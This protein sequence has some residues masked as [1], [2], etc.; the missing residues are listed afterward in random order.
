MKIIQ[1]DNHFTLVGDVVAMHCF[2]RLPSQLNSPTYGATTKAL[3]IRERGI[4]EGEAGG[5]KDK[6]VDVLAGF[7]KYGVR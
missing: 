1:A 6:V 7:G 5:D 2:S 3:L 4:K